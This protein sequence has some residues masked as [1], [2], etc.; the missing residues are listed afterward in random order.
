MI[1]LHCHILPG[2][3]DGPAN[4]EGAVALA[5]A[6]LQDGVDRVVATPHESALRLPFAG[7]RLQGMIEKLRPELARQGVGLRLLAGLEVYL[8]PDTPRTHGEGRAFTLNG[9]RYL[10]VEL[11]P[12]MVPPYAEETLFRLQLRKLVP[13]IAHPERNLEVAANPEVLRRMVRHGMLAQVTAGSLAGRY[14]GQVRRVAETLMRQ[15]LIHLIASDAHSAE[16]GPRLLSE[17]VRRAERLV[18]EEAALAMVT[19]LPAAILNDEDVEP[20]EPRPVRRRSW[21]F[22][23][24]Q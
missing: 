20:P 18:G 21:F 9:S 16:D 24:Q 22:F 23:R 5:R 2:V 13:V 15:R 1:D 19:E 14:G 4:V 11:P 3:D 12:Q 17:G 7:A 10:L 8:S 6:L